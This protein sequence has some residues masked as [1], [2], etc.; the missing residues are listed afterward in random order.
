MGDVGGG[1]TEERGWQR[2]MGVG[3]FRLF[4]LER[5]RRRGGRRERKKER[6]GTVVCR[7]PATFTAIRFY[8]TQSNAK[9]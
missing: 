9:H 7:L 1:V 8:L 5:E 4:L 6:E 3:V 2:W